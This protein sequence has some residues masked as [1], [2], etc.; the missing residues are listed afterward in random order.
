[1][2]NWGLVLS[3]I[4][5]TTVVFSNPVEKVTCEELKNSAIESLNQ[6]SQS[7]IEKEKEIFH[8]VTSEMDSF[9]VNN[10]NIFNSRL[11]T[12]NEAL[13]KL[14]IWEGKNPNYQEELKKYDQTTGLPASYLELQKLSDKVVQTNETLSNAF[15]ASTRIFMNKNKLY[16][17]KYNGKLDNYQFNID[18][19]S[20]GNSYKT[21][22]SNTVR[23]DS[24]D[25]F[26]LDSSGPTVIAHLDIFSPNVRAVEL[27]AFFNQ[28]NLAFKRKFEDI[29]TK[30][31]FCFLNPD[32]EIK[33]IRTSV[34]LHYN[35]ETKTYL[36]EYIITGQD[37]NG[38]LQDLY[39]G[40]DN[41]F[42]AE[43]F[44]IPKDCNPI[45]LGDEIM[46]N[47]NIS[48]DTIKHMQQFEGIKIGGEGYGS[49]LDNETIKKLGIEDS[50]SPK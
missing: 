49:E 5:N 42:I 31:Q 43:N 38:I 12:Y 17:Y 39:T 35:L 20:N 14:T 37:K 11:R 3:L 29:E 36:T 45:T 21:L 34:K 10:V 15:V 19:F 1:M 41:E 6:K 48:S 7:L 27:D 9:R 40:F 30:D 25:V 16:K 24:G 23:T 33:L 26:L 22:F 44:L 18:E 46:R 32:E 4:L 28:R 8:V 13:N 50:S 2:R 47:R